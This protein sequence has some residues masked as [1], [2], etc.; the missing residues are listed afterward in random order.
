LV[1]LAELIGLPRVTTLYAQRHQ[2]ASAK[3]AT[4]TPVDSQEAR[5]V[6]IFAA[7]CA[8]DRLQSMMFNLPSATGHFRIPARPIINESDGSVDVHAYAFSSSS[9]AVRVQEIDEDFTSGQPHAEIYNRVIL[10]DY[11]LRSLAAKAPKRWWNPTSDEKTYI[12]DVNVLLVQFL[13]CYQTVRVHLHFALKDDYNEGAEVDNNA[14][15]NNGHISH[16]SSPYAYSRS[17]CIEACKAVA[18]RYPALRAMIPNGF[19]LARLVHIQ[20]FTVTTVL[21]LTRHQ[22]LRNAARSGMR[23]IDPAEAQEM[24]DYALQMLTALEDEATKPGSEFAREESVALRALYA[25]LEDPTAAP[26][27]RL[28]LQIPMLGKVHIGRRPQRQAPVVE[29]QV[30]TTTA[31]YPH[32]QMQ[33][34]PMQGQPT[35]ISQYIP[36][37]PVGQQIQQDDLSWLLELDMNAGM[38]N[39]FLAATGADLDG[40]MDWSSSN[41]NSIYPDMP[42]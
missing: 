17:A 23:A 36:A 7:M 2:N 28:A 14:F 35:M 34:A 21:L 42:S 37:V 3:S 1:A 33:T 6:E 9:I 40:W 29:Q 24:H 31:Y 10:A 16:N 12:P 15:A 19:F 4:S 22:N 39:P 11:E 8:A 13:H 20:V 5:K 25:L 30:P 26:A 32:E 38:Q 27:E 41:A 18:R